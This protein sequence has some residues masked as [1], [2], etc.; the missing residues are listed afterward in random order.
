MRNVSSS[1]GLGGRPNRATKLASPTTALTVWIGPTT[2]GAAS[3][4]TG[5][6]RPTWVAMTASSMICSTRPPGRAPGPVSSKAWY[7]R[8][9]EAIEGDRPPGRAGHPAGRLVRRVR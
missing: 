1:V 9:D 7:L 8:A 2:D 3:L 6:A 4:S 5:T